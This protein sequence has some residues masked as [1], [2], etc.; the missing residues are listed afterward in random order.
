MRSAGG[1]SLPVP[2]HL[3]IGA[4]IAVFLVALVLVLPLGA[5]GV[6]I[7]YATGAIVS[8]PLAAYAVVAVLVLLLAMWGVGGIANAFFWS[9]WT[10]IYLRLTGRLTDRLELPA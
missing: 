6:A 7:F 2:G 1:R 10:L 5:L 4:G 3:S 9:Y 8:I